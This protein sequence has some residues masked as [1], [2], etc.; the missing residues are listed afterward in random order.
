MVPRLNFCVRLTLAT[1]LEQPSRLRNLEELHI[2]NV[3]HGVD[4]RQEVEWMAEYWP[5]LRRLV[6][7]E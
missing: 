5:E 2:P 7:L 4:S 3:D 1:G 6:G